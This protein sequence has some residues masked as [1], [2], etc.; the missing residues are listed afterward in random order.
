MLASSISLPRLE[1]LRVAE[2][3]DLSGYLPSGRG[4]ESP[5]FEVYHTGYPCGRWYAFAATWLDLKAPRRGCV[6][7]HTLFIDKGDLAQMAWPWALAT[8]HRRPADASDLDGF[9]VPLEVDLSC[10]VVPPGVVLEDGA[11]RDLAYDRRLEVARA[12]FALQQR[13]LLWDA[14]KGAAEVFGWLWWALWPAARVDLSFCTWV[15]NL[16]RG[17]DRAT[18]MHLLGVPVEAQRHLLQ[19]RNDL[20][21]RGGG[22]GMSEVLLRRLARQGRE[23]TRRWEAAW[24]AA[25]VESPAMGRVG[26]LLEMLGLG[27]EG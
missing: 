18:P 9:D 5:P 12:F 23:E 3:S 11:P 24:R 17:L 6:L 8:L 2:L 19:Q 4:A 14:N 22:A 21:S 16:R 10:E 27:E 13:P 7:T 20:A 25:G 26:A 15:V 1:D